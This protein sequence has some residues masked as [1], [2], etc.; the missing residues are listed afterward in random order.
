MQHNNCFRKRSEHSKMS[1]RGYHT[2]RE[3]SATRHIILVAKNKLKTSLVGGWVG[4]GYFVPMQC[5]VVLSE[6][7][8]FVQ[9]LL[10]ILTSFWVLSAP[11]NWLKHF[12]TT[13]QSW[14][15][16]KRCSTPSGV[17]WICLFRL[18]FYFCVRLLDY[19]EMMN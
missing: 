6:L 12:Y 15:T 9:L 8:V 16:C 17:P 18:I 4:E 3:G 7:N 11:K 10:C 5:H 14:L 2:S 13:L 19:S 1:D